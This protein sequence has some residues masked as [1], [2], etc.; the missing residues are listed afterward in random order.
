MVRRRRSCSP[1]GEAGSGR[2]R[3]GRRGHR[4]GATLDHGGLGIARTGRAPGRHGRD[5]A[6]PSLKP[7]AAPENTP[8]PQD[9]ER[10]DQTK[11]DEVDREATGQ[12]HEYPFQ[13]RGHTTTTIPFT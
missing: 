5:G 7:R 12:V 2:G 13:V 3:T 11:E 6:R 9:Q 1:R 8:Q 4:L 10:G